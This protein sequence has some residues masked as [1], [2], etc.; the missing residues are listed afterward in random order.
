MESVVGESAV[1][2]FRGGK[3][4]AGTE[5]FEIT[6]VE[7]ARA[8]MNYL[9]TESGGHIDGFLGF[10]DISNADTGNKTSVWVP[11]NVQCLLRLDYDLERG[12]IKGACRVTLLG[13][14]GNRIATKVYLNDKVSGV[15]E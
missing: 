13:E 5:Y 11:P 14:P 3:E 8:L 4:A 15:F 1:K 7:K 12:Q 2:G 9:Q 10:K 6:D